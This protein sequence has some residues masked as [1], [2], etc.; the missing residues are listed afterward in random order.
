MVNPTGHKKDTFTRSELKQQLKAKEVKVKETANKLFQEEKGKWDKETRGLKA[1][2]T[3]LEAKIKEL[4][5]ELEASSSSKGKVGAVVS[6]HDADIQMFKIKKAAEKF[7]KAEMAKLS[8]R[9]DAL[10]E[11]NQT[12]RSA[13]GQTE[14]LVGPV[15]PPR[16]RGESPASI[17][18]RDT[19]PKP[20]ARQSPT[21]APTPPAAGIPPPPPP[22]STG[23]GGIPPPPP[24]PGMMAPV[25]QLPLHKQYRNA[26][27]LLE[28]AENTTDITKLAKAAY[29]TVKDHRKKVETA[30][31][32]ADLIST[33]FGE[34]ETSVQ[35]VS[36][37]EK[38]LAQ[39]NGKT[40]FQIETDDGKT[41]RALYFG[42]G[43][44]PEGMIKAGTIEKLRQKTEKHRDAALKEIKTD[45][46]QIVSTTADF[47]KTVG[48]F[49]ATS[50][51]IKESL[52]EF[53]DSSKGLERL[54]V[55]DVATAAKFSA[56][57]TNLKAATQAVRHAQ[58]EYGNLVEKK[59]DHIFKLRS[60][61]GLIEKGGELVK[62][63]AAPK[64]KK[65]AAPKVK[66][67]ATDPKLPSIMSDPARFLLDNL[68]L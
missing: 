37:C 2:I 20:A 21:A 52:R 40:E 18:S 45:M 7:F 17:P 31:A 8:K 14:E 11:E 51:P 3:K 22:M 29:K 67:A 62:R 30:K 16:S 12:L 39:I 1:R 58:Q 38:L 68:D 25:A 61:A 65:A 4:E 26:G 57:L 63:G 10:E 53:Y 15:T 5:N 27:P 28:K 13:R 41:L 46:H 42:P 48:K 9:M 64:A 60:K 33:R 44:A 50:K 66:K 59:A 54:E 35:T 6:R 23:P 19:S 49:A 34:I 32:Q 43:K 24:P 55:K 47:C 56:A 36:K